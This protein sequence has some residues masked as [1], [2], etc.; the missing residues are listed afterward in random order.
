MLLDLEPLKYKPKDQR[1][2]RLLR[3]VMVIFQP[4]GSQWPSLK[5]RIDVAEALGRAGNPRLRQ[6]NWVTIPA[7]TFVM[8]EGANAHDV[9]LNAYEIGKYPVTVEEYGKYV[10]EGGA[11]PPDWEEQTEYPNR[12]VVRVSWHDADG[13]CRWAGLRLPTEAEWE[14]AARGAEGRKYPWGEE[15]PDPS[16]ANY[17]KTGVGAPTPVGLFPRGATPNGICD[18][19]GNVWEWVADWYGKYPKEKQQ[20]PKGPSSGEMRVLR[21]GAWHL[22]SRDLRGADRSR[23]EPGDWYSGFVV[24][25][26]CCSLDP[27]FLFLFHRGEAPSRKVLEG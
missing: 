24:P 23:L 20:N 11:A 5:T 25:G 16:R 22:V 3:A 2:E 6:Q 15:E 14:R 9:E 12:P 18:M 17:E 7:G 19:A 10:E 26:K 4:A 8:G 1:Y 27:F 21:G 13:Y